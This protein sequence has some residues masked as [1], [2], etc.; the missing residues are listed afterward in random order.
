M[1][2]ST[3]VLAQINYFN[4]LAHS[5]LEAIKKYIAFEKMIEKGETLLYEGDQS[6]YMYFLVSGVVKVYKRSINGKEQILNLASTGESLNDV[7][8]FDGDG[9]AADMLAMTPARIY[10]VRKEDMKALLAKYP[11]V[12]LNAVG[13]LASKVRGDSSLVE[14]LSFDLVI[15]RL[16]RFLLKQAAAG[17]YTLSLLTQQD[18]A[19]MV[20]ASRVVV[21]RSLRT[22]EG[23]GAIRLVRRRIIITDEGV[24]KTLVT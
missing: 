17:A 9:S 22:M 1:V 20:G 4:G 23:K 12:A 13:V 10:A 21:N 6:N 5:E 24:L 15:S 11:K 2:I 16:A 7:S 8:T 3:A 18:M 14:V 19:A